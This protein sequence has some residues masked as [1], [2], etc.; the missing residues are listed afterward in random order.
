MEDTETATNS[1]PLYLGPVRRKLSSDAEFF[2]EGNTN[3]ALLCKINV[4]AIIA[5]GGEVDEMDILGQQDQQRYECMFQDCTASFSSLK[6]HE[7]H[8]E[9]SHR[10]RCSACGRTFPT[11]RLLDFHLSEAHDSFF[12]AMAER[13]P[14]YACLVE[15]CSEVFETS[16]KRH[17]HLIDAHR[18]PERFDF[19]R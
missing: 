10:N 1:G 3:R 5:R 15:G 6:R 4:F 19:S 14:M 11:H 7:E 2:D 13:R 16:G 12:R 17:T 8:Y 9:T 18:Y